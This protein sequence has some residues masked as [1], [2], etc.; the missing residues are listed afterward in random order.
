ME[1]DNNLSEDEEVTL[2]VS[3]GES[4]FKISAL[5]KTKISGM[6]RVL[7]KLT[8]S[9]ENYEKKTKKISQNYHAPALLT[10]DKDD[11]KMTFDGDDP[12]N[13]ISLRLEMDY[14]KIKNSSLFGVKDGKIQIFK[15]QRITPKDALLIITFIYE[16]GLGN[17]AIPY[18]D[19]KEAFTMSNIKS[20]SPL[21][22]LISNCTKAGYLDKAR[23]DSQKE[24]TLTPKGEAQV[25]KAIENAL[26]S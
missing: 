14:D 9:L 16:T 12:M 2:E 22:M 20:K 8:N 4:A 15:A 19:M 6:D 10:K 26:K 3:I 13:K 17:S 11:E 23:Y 25:K 1:E 18:E 24:I 21:Y 7:S 5:A